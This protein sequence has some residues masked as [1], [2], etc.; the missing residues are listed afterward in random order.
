MASSKCVVFAFIP[1][2]EAGNAALLPN[3]IEAILSPGEQLMNIGL[4]AH[5]PDQLVARG[6]EYGVECDREFD[7]SEICAEVAAGLGNRVDEFRPDFRCQLNQ[8]CVGSALQVARV[9]NRRED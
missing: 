7:R 1:G 9:G 3:R 6:V 4:V 8:F 5:V 2:K